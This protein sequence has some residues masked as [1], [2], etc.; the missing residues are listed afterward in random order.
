M[1]LPNLESEKTPDVSRKMMS[2]MRLSYLQF[3]QDKLEFQPLSSIVVSSTSSALRG[4][5]VWA[6]T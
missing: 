6:I 4:F 3:L 2:C 5:L 1:K